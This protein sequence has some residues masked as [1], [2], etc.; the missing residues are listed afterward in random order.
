MNEQEL[1]KYLKDGFKAAQL[2]YKPTWERRIRNFNLYIGTLPNLP[3]AY[4]NYNVPYVATLLDNVWPLLTNRMPVS[5]VKARN[6]RDRKPASLMKELLDYTFDVNSFDLTFIMGQKESDFFGDFFL[7][8]CWEYSDGKKYDHASLIPLNSMDVVPHP[9]KI[10]LDDDFPLYIRSEM[11]KADMIKHGWDKRTINS[12]G[13]SK[14]GTPQYRKEMLASLGYSPAE[15]DKQGELK[16][17]L[18][19]VVECWGMMDLSF[20]TDDNTPLQMACV[21]IANDDKAINVKPPKGLQKFE[22]PYNHGKIPVSQMKFNPYPHMFLSESFID[23][24]AD[25]QMELNELEREKVNN[26]RRRNNPPMQVRRK[27]EVDL[28]KLKF[29]QSIPW[30]VNEI[31]DIEP[32]LVPDLAP[33]IENQQ[34]MI[35]AIMQSRSGANDVLLVS[36]TNELKGGDTALGAS[37]A[38]ENTKMRFRPQATLIDVFFER[39]G[40]LLI[41]MYQDPR[42]FD[43]KM[44]LAIADE[45]GNY[46]QEMVSNKDVQGDL[47][48]KV[49]ASSSLAQSNASRLQTLVNI[50]TLYAED[51]SVNQDE[52][53]KGIFDAADLDFNKIKKDKEALISDAATQLKKFISIA[54]SPDFQSMPPAQ[55]QEI[56]G[57]I[58]RLKQIVESSQQNAGGMVQPA[59]V[60][61]E[62]VPTEGGLQ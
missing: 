20:G 26:Y 25:L 4:A 49:M 38:N 1:I 47:Q 5:T 21:V 37:I 57:Q 23:P 31:G 10:T 22:S 16:D 29:V 43:Q 33:S 12:L 2:F 36:D 30:M 19:E 24:L 52:I 13:K 18:Y 56:L 32:F 48:F 62:A 35:K 50:K 53:D 7:K 51:Q 15:T 59:Q 11:T 14:L 60:G 42:Y 6:D 28:T 41:S 45:E 58:D 44:A 40:E 8:V 27:G 17:D 55:Q 54:Q 3:K 9:K 46:Y 61:P 39:T 34:N